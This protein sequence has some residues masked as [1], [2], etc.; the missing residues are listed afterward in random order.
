[1]DCPGAL[2]EDESADCSKESIAPSCMGWKI[3]GKRETGKYRIKPPNTG[4]IY[5]ITLRKFLE[6]QYVDQDY[7]II[8]NLLK[9][10]L[11]MSICA[12]EYRT[13]VCHREEGLYDKY[14][15]A[16]LSANAVVT[17]N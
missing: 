8:F 4:K 17:G 12:L 2:H 1:M 7:G 6:K 10:R 14:S 9:E 15:I 5:Q 16:N 11:P 3:A 13:H